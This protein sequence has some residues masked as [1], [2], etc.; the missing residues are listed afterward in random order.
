M[1]HD[2]GNIVVNVDKHVVEALFHARRPS[3][4]FLGKFAQLRVRYLVIT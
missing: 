1:R 2:R 4:H 3:R